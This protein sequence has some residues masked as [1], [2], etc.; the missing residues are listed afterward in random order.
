[1]GLPKL[2]NSGII[3]KSPICE[4]LKAQEKAWLQQ[5]YCG[6]S[7]GDELKEGSH[8]LWPFTK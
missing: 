6:R 4:L 1:M 5:V 3:R 7:S 8:L 2:D